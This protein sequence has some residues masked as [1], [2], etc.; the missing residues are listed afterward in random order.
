MDYGKMLASHVRDQADMTIGCIKVPQAEATA[1]G[2]MTV[3][4]KNRIVAFDE[5][6]E[7]PA[8]MPGQPGCALASMGI[9]VFNTQFLYEQLIR[10]AYDSHSTHDFGHDIAN[11]SEKLSAHILD[12]IRAQTPNFC[13]D[14]KR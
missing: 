10:D 13:H 9:Y 3:N 7:N 11:F 1:F 14:G 5:K 4:E 6:P 12:F 2:V 8:P